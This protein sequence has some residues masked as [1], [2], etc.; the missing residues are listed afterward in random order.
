MNPDSQNTERGKA[1][2]AHSRHLQYAK[3]SL[4]IL[5]AMTDEKFADITPN[6]VLGRFCGSRATREEVIARFEAVI[7]QLE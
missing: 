1:F 3:D 2:A 5:V 6:H 4:G 7:A